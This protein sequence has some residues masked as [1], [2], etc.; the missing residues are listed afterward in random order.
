MAYDDFVAAHR[1]LAARKGYFTNTARGVYVRE[2]HQELTGL[3]APCVAGLD[4]AAHLQALAKQANKT[5]S[6]AKGFDKNTRHII[7]KEIGVLGIKL[8]KDYLDQRV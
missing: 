5:L 8:L 1:K 3:S 4:Q 7:A 2:R 6:E